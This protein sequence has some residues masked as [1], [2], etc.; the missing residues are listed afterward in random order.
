[1]I[2]RAR[3]AIHGV[4]GLPAELWA[5]VSQLSNEQAL[6]HLQQLTSPAPRELFDALDL[7]K[8]GV[9]SYPQLV[10]AFRGRRKG[11]NKGQ[12]TVC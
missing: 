4:P 7:D 1:M 9:I 11:A 12:L 5:L 10:K 2:E 8:D 6:D 3:A